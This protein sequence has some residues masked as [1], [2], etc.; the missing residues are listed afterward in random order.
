MKSEDACRWA[1]KVENEGMW[2]LTLGSY[3]RVGG[4]ADFGFQ[5]VFRDIDQRDLARQDEWDVLVQEPLIVPSKAKVGEEEYEAERSDAGLIDTIKGNTTETRMRDVQE[6]VLVR[7]RS[8]DIFENGKDYE[9]VVFVN[10]PYTLPEGNL[11]DTRFGNP[12]GNSPTYERLDIVMPE[13]I[14]ESFGE[15]VRDEINSGSGNLNEF[16]SALVHERRDSSE[17]L[18]EEILNG[19]GEF[20]PKSVTYSEKID[21]H[22]QVKDNDRYADNPIRKLHSDETY[23][24]SDIEEP[25]VVSEVQ[26]RNW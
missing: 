15:Y 12:R 20:G 7:P 11:S 17:E 22:R 13:I 3:D 4:N 14:G 5:S 2:S 24:D 8:K 9:D 1:E 16:V 26:R 10:I 6:D 18:V 23:E 21:A 25:A 19:E